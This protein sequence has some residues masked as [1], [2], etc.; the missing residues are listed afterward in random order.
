MGVVWFLFTFPMICMSFLDVS[1]ES[2]FSQALLKFGSCMFVLLFSQTC[3]GLQV[4]QESLF[5]YAAP[6]ALHT[7]INPKMH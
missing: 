3:R 6:K 7:N 5:E 2:L 4:L 1:H